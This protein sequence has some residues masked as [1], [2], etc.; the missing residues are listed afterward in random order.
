MCYIYYYATFLRLRREC[1]IQNLLEK[2][3]WTNSYQNPMQFDLFRTNSKSCRTWVVQD[4]AHQPYHNKLS[5]TLKKHYSPQSVRA[6]SHN[7]IEELRATIPTDIEQVTL[8][9]IYNNMLVVNYYNTNTI[10]ALTY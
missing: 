1:H 5:D 7:D 3:F 6:M 10:L 8:S 9:I 4:F 2:S